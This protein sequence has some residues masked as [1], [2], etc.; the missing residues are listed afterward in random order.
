MVGAGDGADL[1]DHGLLKLVDELQAGIL[2]LLERDEGG[3]AGL[4][5]FVLGGH[6]LSLL[7]GLRAPNPGLFLATNRMEDAPRAERDLSKF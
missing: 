6:Y 1:L 5:D 4:L 7:E 3:D 2:P